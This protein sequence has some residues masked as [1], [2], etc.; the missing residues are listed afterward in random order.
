MDHKAK[1]I[2]TEPWNLTLRKNPVMILAIEKKKHKTPMKF[3]TQKKIHHKLIRNT[4]EP[5]LSPLN[6]I[7][8]LEVKKNEDL[9]YAKEEITPNY[10][11]DM[12]PHLLLF[13]WDDRS[14]EDIVNKLGRFIKQA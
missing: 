6:S 11:W 10:L 12:L 8:N 2:P 14:L 5:S 4:P 3:H 1:Y 9:Y 7:Q 13:F